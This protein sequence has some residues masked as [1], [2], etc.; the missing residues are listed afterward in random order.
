V[1]NT[2]KTTDEDWEHKAAQIL[3]TWEWSKLSCTD[4]GK[5]FCTEECLRGCH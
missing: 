2:D 3:V 5:Y 1:I 4:V